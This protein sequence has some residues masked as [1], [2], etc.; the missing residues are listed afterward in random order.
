M[1]RLA[2]PHNQNASFPLSTK[3]DN[4]EMNESIVVGVVRE[5]ELLVQALKQDLQGLTQPKSWKY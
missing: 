4:H 3:I 2:K 5:R 1:H